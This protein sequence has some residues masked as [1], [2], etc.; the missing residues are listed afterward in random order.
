MSERESELR[1]NLALA[2][3]KLSERT[4]QHDE[5]QLRLVKNDEKLLA[6][7]SQ[8]A[9]STR[10]NREADANLS[11]SNALLES[12]DLEL[13][14]RTAHLAAAAMELSQRTNQLHESNRY[15]LAK[16]AELEQA[17]AGLK[18]MI[19]Q[20]EDFV[21]ALTHDLKN[22]LIGSTRILELLA[23]GQ[24]PNEK[25]SEIFS[26]LFESNKSM[27]RMIW[28]LLEVYRHESGALVALYES[29]D[30]AE[31][32][33][34]CLDEFAFGIKA[35]KLDL[36]LDIPASVPAVMSDKILLRRVLVNLLDNAVK[37][38]PEAG[39]LTV[40]ATFDERELRIYVKDSGSGMSDEQLG[41][42]FQR[43]SQTRHGRA[44]G[45]GNGLG[46][47]L[48]KQIMQELGGSIECTSALG[49]GAQFTVT[50]PLSRSA[51]DNLAAI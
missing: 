3:E 27:L 41:L 30:V 17:N 26:Q 16:T 48:S 31:L 11:V 28:N 1:L 46:L 9:E 39:K 24:I 8:L 50:I 10:Q 43:F 32:L 5:V 25:Q 38:S 7:Q 13:A 21:A 14:T 47:F 22:P 42:I 23:A 15:L 37:F 51:P 49:R 29:V 36:C 35:K 6:I 2:E 20:R 19:Q 45:T 33:Q 44:H 40:G 18:A 34:N 12:K 4:R